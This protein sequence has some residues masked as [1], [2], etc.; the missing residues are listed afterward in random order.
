[1]VKK[2]T[3]V[4]TTSQIIA[5]VI[6]FALSSCRTYYDKTLTF[7]KKYE[8]GEYSEARDYLRSQKKLKKSN[9]KVLYDLDYAM[10]SFMMDSTAASIA[11]F[12][13]ADRY[14]EDFSKNY[15]YEALALIS[16]PMVR[17]Y[18]VE[19]YERVMIHFFQALNYIKIGEEE[20]AL[21]ECRRM[22]LVLNQLSDAFKKHDGKRYSRDAFGHYMM[23]VLYEMAGDD[24]N[25]FIA[26]RNAL[27]IYEDDYA[28][29]FGMPVPEVIK[30][31][32]IRTAYRT[33]FTTEL[34]KYENKFRLK[35]KESAKGKGRLV[36]FMLDGMSPVKTEVNVDFVKN[37]NG[38]VVNFSNGDTGLTIPILWGDCTS[39]EKSSL[40]DVSYIR[41]AIPQYISRGSRC[42]G[43]LSINGAAQRID[44][45]EDVDK[46]ARQSLKDRLW[47][48]LGKSLLR[49]A[50]KEAIHQAAAKQ[51]E[52]AGLLV[53]IMNAVTEKADT[54]SWMSLPSKIRVV[55]VELDAGTYNVD[56]SSC[57]TNSATIDV[58]EGR[59][60]FAV[61]RGF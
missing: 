53:N 5:I 59:T 10:S 15:S 56:Y 39:S 9:V 28:R 34:L 2:Y 45:V 30:T 41:M 26:Y 29:L 44:V 25:A 13:Q 57:A 42:D 21:V 47:R 35:H 50:A 48:E 58:S 32:I 18:E 31:G 23:A 12:D 3:N 17:P 19:Y 36:T 14:A 40:K 55:D 1:M 46:V 61:F 16:N 33:G 27:E 4:V 52:Y 51:N 24:N 54:R 7:N 6:C 22:N 37:R 49:T 11:H 8:Q 38:G 60:T 20:D 43:V